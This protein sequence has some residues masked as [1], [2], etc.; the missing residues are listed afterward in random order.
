MQNWVEQCSISSKEWIWTVFC[1]WFRKILCVFPYV[2]MNIYC[3]S[4]FEDNIHIKWKCKELTILLNTVSKPF[5]IFLTITC[6]VY[7]SIISLEYFANIMKF[8]LLKKSSLSI[9]CLFLSWGT[10]THLSSSLPPVYGHLAVNLQ[11]FKWDFK[12]KF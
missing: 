1:Y 3:L 7:D 12:S 11:T 10:C 9:S 8:L 2:Y 5:H 4:Y 6:V